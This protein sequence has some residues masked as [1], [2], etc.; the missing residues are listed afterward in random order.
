M[1]KYLSLQDNVYQVY[2]RLKSRKKRQE[3]L[4]KCFIFGFENRE[5]ES[6]SDVNLAFFGVKPSLFLRNS[7]GGANNLNGKNQ[8]NSLKNAENF[9]QSEVNQWSELGQP[10]LNNKKEKEKKQK[11]KEESLKDKN[12]YPI[13]FSII[14]LNE[15]D[16]NLWKETYPYL[17][18][19]AECMM[20]NNWLE[21]QPEEVKKKW[22][23]TTAKYFI[24]QN[25][26]RK[27]QQDEENKQSSDFD[28]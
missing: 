11:N 17:N 16:F 8:H 1:S 7:G 12:I 23:V 14:K 26:I 28:W 22:F 27:K 18:I 5:I 3:F 4:E 19:R 15:K 10:F 24:K 2:I 25:E 20:R 6:S 9:G 21:T 13:T